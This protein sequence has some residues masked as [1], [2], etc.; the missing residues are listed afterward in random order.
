MET[1]AA[2]SWRK[3][4]YSTSNGGDCVEVGTAPRTI[5]VRDSKDPHGPA[6]AFSRERW[7]TFTRRLKTPTAYH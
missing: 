6:L 3:S 1:A 5:A 4:S 2:L 7:D